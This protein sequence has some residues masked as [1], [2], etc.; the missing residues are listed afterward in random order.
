MVDMSRAHV[1]AWDARP[2]PDFPDRLETW[3]DGSNHARGHWLNGRSGVALADVVS[4]ICARC[5]I[6][7]TDVEQ[8]HG[9]VTG[10]AV[11]AVETA[12]QS[13]QPLMLGYCFDSNTIEGRLA[14]ANRGGS[15]VIQLHAGSCVA[16]GNQPVVTLTR[17]PAAEAAER[18]S[19]GF[20]R[21]DMD[22]ATGAV[23]A[24]APEA[25]EPRTEQMSLPLVLSEGEAR[26]VAARALSE[27]QVARETLGCSVPLSRMSLSPGDLISFPTEGG[28]LYRVDRIEDAGARSIIGVRVEPAVYQV[29]VS[30]VRG[31]RRQTLT[32]PGPVTVQFLDLPLLT[33]DEAPVGSHLAVARAP[34]SGAVAVYTA[35][36]DHGYRFQQDVRRPAVIG[37]LLDPLP[38]AESGRWMRAGA[39]VRVSGSLQGRS[40]EDVLNGANAAALRFGPEGD[41]EV[42]QFELAELVAPKTYMLRK[43][44]RGQAGTDAVVPDVWPAGT[45]FVLLDGAVQQLPLPSSARGRAKHYRIGPASRSYDDPSYVHRIEVSLGTGLRP[46]R[47]VHLSARRRS[48]GAVEVTWFRRT[49]VDGDSWLGTDV[50]LGEEGEAYVVRIYD[51][52]A[53]AREAETSS[54]VYRYT[55]ADQ[56]SDGVAGALTI[57]VAQVSVRFGPGPFERIEF[58]G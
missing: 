2:W 18:V 16:A 55:E 46:Y 20:V 3:T 4:E 44:L 11:E 27:A 42:I 30:E 37:E 10:Y 17:S 26:A 32:A 34:W 58:D 22:Y 9:S 8:L 19:V 45:T 28:I 1:W 6:Q 15:S 24:L 51:A 40:E 7:E 48:D 53:L 13:L 47:P 36:S 12:R 35:N 38:W 25:S 43:L 56:A 50:P 14:F 5:E 39:R 33:G 29:P 41:W 57:E 54:S 52:G 31:G 23:E 21:A 49:R